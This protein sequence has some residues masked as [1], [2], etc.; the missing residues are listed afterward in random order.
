MS[1]TENEDK[2]IVFSCRLKQSTKDYIYSE[3]KRIGVP[4]TQTMEYIIEQAIKNQNNTAPASKEIAP[5]AVE[6]LFN[7]E[8]LNRLKTSIKADENVNFNTALEIVLNMN[9]ELVKENEI[10]N[11]REPQIITETKEVEVIKTVPIALEKNQFICT[12][13]DAEATKLR[14][15]R[16]FM[17]QDGRIKQNAEP[18][19]MMPMFI[20]YYLDSK[21]D[22]VLNPF[23]R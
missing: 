18:N 5:V 3:S 22:H 13:P 19:E 11:H 6:S 21:Y 10:L 7:I 2:L 8:N 23:F 16:K 4:I 17:I 12:L 20:N 1:E 15:C 9:D 14:K